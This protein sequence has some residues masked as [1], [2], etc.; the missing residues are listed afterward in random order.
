MKQVINQTVTAHIHSLNGGL[1]EATILEKPDI[2][3][4]AYVAMYRGVKCSAIF[5]PFAG[6]YVDDVYGILK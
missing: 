3:K 6:W 4:N 1:A 5:N 2:N